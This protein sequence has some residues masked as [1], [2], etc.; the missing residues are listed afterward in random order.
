MGPIQLNAKFGSLEKSL[1]NWMVSDFGITSDCNP[2]ESLQIET[3]ILIPPKALMLQL[4]RIE[5]DQYGGF[6]KL[7]IE[8][9]F[10]LF[11]D[12][13]QLMSP[14]AHGVPSKYLLVAVIIHMG[15]ATGGHYYCYVRD[16]SRDFWWRMND[17]EVKI[18]ER[19][20]EI[21]EEMEHNGST[22]VYAAAD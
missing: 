14:L 22:L 8:F 20:G 2:G 19:I 1:E 15:T 7:D 9:Q 13:T 5:M 16:R 17:S 11:L 3:K 10:P 4:N 6:K 18:V 21:I 12:L